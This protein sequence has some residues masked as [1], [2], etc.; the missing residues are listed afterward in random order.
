MIDDIPDNPFA[1]FSP[2]KADKL[3][4][5]AEEI[6]EGEVDAA[7][8]FAACLMGLAPRL[9]IATTML[10]YVDIQAQK[11]ETQK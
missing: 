2:A 1:N 4:A 11:A 6:C 9:E 7:A 5:L 10:E 8:H 3:I